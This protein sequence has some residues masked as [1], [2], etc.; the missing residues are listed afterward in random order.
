MYSGPVAAT[1]YYELARNGRPRSV[2]IIGPNHTGMGSG[3]SLMNEGSW[4]TPLGEVK[5]D[6]QL[7]NLIL[8][9]AQIIDLDE[10]AHLY[11]HSIEVQLPFLQYLYGDAFT[12]VPICMMIQDL[13]TG[14]EVGEAIAQVASEPG[15]LVIASSD[16]THY[17]PHELASKKD[18]KAI[19][20]IERMDESMLDEVVAS[21]SLSICGVGPI[22]SAIAYSKRRG[23]KSARLLSY[24]TSGEISGDYTSVVGYAAMLF[25][26]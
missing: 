12:F 19:R 14:R 17:E 6:S 1:A 22:V 25:H 11:E 9:G 10:K 21:E 23:V 2:V 13:Q 3:V 20:A 26:I 16:M 5:I 7:A 24:R 15:S 18:M 4:S 8:E